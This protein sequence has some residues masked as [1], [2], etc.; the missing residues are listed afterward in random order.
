MCNDFVKTPVFFEK[1]CAISF[2]GEAELAG[3]GKL[4]PRGEVGA[5]WDNRGDSAVGDG[6]WVGYGA[7]IWTGATGEAHP[8]N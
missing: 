3:I 8:C 5:W 7:A 1:Q 4:C 6:V 2:P